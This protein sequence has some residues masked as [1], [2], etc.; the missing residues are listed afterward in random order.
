MKKGGFWKMRE[1][2]IGSASKQGVL[3]SLKLDFKQKVG[4]AFGEW[5]RWKVVNFPELRGGLETDLEQLVFFGVWREERTAKLAKCSLPRC[6][7]ARTD[8]FIQ[9]QFEVQFQRSLNPLATNA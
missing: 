1:A 7:H 2:K 4:A 8:S 6:K 5:L 9:F 3:A